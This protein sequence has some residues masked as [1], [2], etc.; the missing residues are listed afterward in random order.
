MRQCGRWHHY[1][2]WD[3]VCAVRQLTSCHE[4]AS[5]RPCQT[6]E[7][8]VSVVISGFPSGGDAAVRRPSRRMNERYLRLNLTWKTRI[9]RG[10]LWRRRSVISPSTT[11]AASVPS[12]TTGRHDVRGS[13]P[14]GSPEKVS[15]FSSVIVVSHKYVMQCNL[16]YLM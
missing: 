6:D 16:F 3:D 11:R 2:A 14:M 7:A 9:L 12:P 5:C 1:K 13:E 10:F 8:R 4:T 15:A